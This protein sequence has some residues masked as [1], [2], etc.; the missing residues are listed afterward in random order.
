MDVVTLLEAGFAWTGERIV[1]LR[2]DQLNARTPCDQWDVRAT[3]NHLIGSIDRLA[4]A[5][6]GKPRPPGFDA[7]ATA[8][9]DQIGDDPAGAYRAASER[10]LAVW[11][12]PGVLDRSCE[13]P[14]GFVPASAA[15]QIS[16]TDVVVHGWDVSRAVG[17][18]ADIPAELATALLEFGKA[19]LPDQVRGR[20]FADPVPIAHG[21]PSDQLVAFLGRQP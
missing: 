5:A 17:E 19:F 1:G 13:L 20:A 4:D 10:A 9:I 7:N 21:S 16:A 15:A 14:I 8:R 18:N 12:S 11:R 6:A 3:L 2:P